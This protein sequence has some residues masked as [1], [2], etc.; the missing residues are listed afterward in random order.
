MDVKIPSI[1]PE[2]TTVVALESVR[3]KIM[4]R[5]MKTILQ[6]GLDG[7]PSRIE[8]HIM[9]KPEMGIFIPLKLTL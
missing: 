2:T 9:L 1:S 5:K 8:S 6:G 7:I 3:S 4:N